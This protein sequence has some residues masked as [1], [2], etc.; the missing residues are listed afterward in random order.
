MSWIRLVRDF[1]PGMSANFALFFKL[2]ANFAL[3]FKLIANFALFHE[4]TANFALF[5][6]LIANNAPFYKNIKFCP[7]YEQYLILRCSTNL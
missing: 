4:L 5:S 1:L 2:I 7:V 3:F 6:K